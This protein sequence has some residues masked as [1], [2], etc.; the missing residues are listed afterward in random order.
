MWPKNAVT[1][2]NRA[3]KLSNNFWFH[4]KQVVICSSAQF[5]FSALFLSRQQRQEGYRASSLQ[6]PPISSPLTVCLPERLNSSCVLFMNDVPRRAAHFYG[7]HLRTACRARTRP[8][9][10]SNSV[11]T[12]GASAELPQYKHRVVQPSRRSKGISRR[13]AQPVTFQEC[14]YR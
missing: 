9:E 12:S 7:R 3:T 1:S 11:R 10:T 13:H 4:G 5:F 2:A 8:Q 14:F 6:R